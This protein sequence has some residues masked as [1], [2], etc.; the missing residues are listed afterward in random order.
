MIALLSNP[1]SVH[2]SATG[3]TIALFSNA[4]TTTLVG[5]FDINYTTSPIPFS[6]V[7]YTPQWAY[8]TYETKVETDPTNKLFMYTTDRYG[9]GALTVSFSTTLV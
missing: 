2:G 8:A 7:A 9:A 1:L 4:L 6:S 3:E 5:L